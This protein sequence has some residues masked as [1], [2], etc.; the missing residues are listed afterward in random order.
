MLKLPHFIE[1]HAE[2]GRLKASG[3]AVTIVR[4]GYIHIATTSALTPAQ[5]GALTRNLTP[6][7]PH[8]EHLTAS[9]VQTNTTEA[10]RWKLTF[11]RADTRRDGVSSNAIF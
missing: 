9:V 1:A 8:S 11:Q 6:S 10:Y 5:P 7:F 2:R 4:M 3:H